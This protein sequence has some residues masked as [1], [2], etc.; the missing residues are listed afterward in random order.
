[1][2]ARPARVGPPGS[3]VAR[4][5]PASATASARTRPRARLPCVDSSSRSADSNQTVHARAAPRM[6]RVSPARATG[7]RRAAAG[8][9]PL[10]RAGSRGKPKAG[11]RTLCEEVAV[12]QGRGTRSKAQG[13]RRRW[14]QAKSRA[15]AVG[16][17]TRSRQQGT[18]SRSQCD[19]AGLRQVAGTG[20]ARRTWVVVQSPAA[21]PAGRRRVAA[22]STNRRGRERWFAGFEAEAEPSTGP[23]LERRSAI[24]PRPDV[25][26]PARPPL[27]WVRCS[28]RRF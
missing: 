18:T 1:M 25:R 10:G 9:P 8:P 22:S 7:T 17:G 12:P 6:G 11:Q 3:G 27:G 2:R 24:A 13:R 28:P 21:A 16:A 19:L 20:T 26:E 15:G 14:E 23:G 5:G 4:G